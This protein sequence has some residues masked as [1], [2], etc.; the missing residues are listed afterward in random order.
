MEGNSIRIGQVL[1]IP[2]AVVS[3]A[4]ENINDSIKQQIIKKH[5]TKIKKSIKRNNIEVIELTGKIKKS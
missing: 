2:T 5:N 4:D 1:K 3:N